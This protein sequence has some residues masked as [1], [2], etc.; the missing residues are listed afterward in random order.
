M[1]PALYA[2]SLAPIAV[3]VGLLVSTVHGYTTLYKRN[4]NQ[5]AVLPRHA[6]LI[7]TS[8]VATLLPMVWSATVR[9]ADHDY[10]WLVAAYASSTLFSIFVIVSVLVSIRKSLRSLDTELTENE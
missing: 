7:A 3:L 8:Y 4:P 6:R 9:V 1:V 10:P 2:L 5:A